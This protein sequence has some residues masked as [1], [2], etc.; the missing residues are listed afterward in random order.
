MNGYQLA[1][2]LHNSTFVSLGHADWLAHHTPALSPVIFRQFLL[3]SAHK[4]EKWWEMY[5]SIFL[6]FYLLLE[7]GGGKEK[8]NKRNIMWLPLTCPLLGTWT[9]TQ[10]CAL[11]GNP[12]SNALVRRPA[13]NPLSYTSQGLNH[14][15]SFHMFYSWRLGE[16]VQDTC[17]SC[18]FSSIFHQVEM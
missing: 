11:I 13:L 5:I 9:A 16:G 10:A 6:R 15:I 1:K 3:G 2:M 4:N 18:V 14:S 12:T 8:E 7:R 17:F